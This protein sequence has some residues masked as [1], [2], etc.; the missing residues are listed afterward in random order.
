MLVL[1][2]P[3]H[4]LVYVII[5]PPSTEGLGECI[6]FVADPISICVVISMTD[7]VAKIS[8]PISTKFVLI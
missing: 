2:L 7:R 1:D 4:P 6:V 5:D 8:R 3:V